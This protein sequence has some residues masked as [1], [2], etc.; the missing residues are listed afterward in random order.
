MRGVPRS[1]CCLLP[2]SPRSY[3]PPTGPSA[4]PTI[5]LCNT[6]DFAI[7]WFSNK[8]H[9]GWWAGACFERSSR[10]SLL[11]LADL[12]PQYP[13]TTTS[14]PGPYNSSPNPVIPQPLLRQYHRIPNFALPYRSTSSL[15]QTQCRACLGLEAQRQERHCSFTVVSVWGFPFGGFNV[16]RLEGSGLEGLGLEGLWLEGWM[17]PGWRVYGL[18]LQGL[19]LEGMGG[20]RWRAQREWHGSAAPS[21]E[22]S[23]PPPPPSPRACPPPSPAEPAFDGQKRVRSLLYDLA[24]RPPP[25]SLC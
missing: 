24:P 1:L 18:G 21:A 5:P 16:G 11:P 12:A 19:G 22:S 7:S 8:C 25:Q 20:C 4:M 2:I 15:N 14:P 23:R 10:K 6:H 3:P 17:V 9:S 13:R